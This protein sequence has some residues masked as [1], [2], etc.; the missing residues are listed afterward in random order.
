MLNNKIL[1]LIA[2][3][4]I[5][6]ISAF[7]YL[8]KGYPGSTTSGYMVLMDHP[9][10]TSEFTTF[11]PE[12]YSST[13]YLPAGTCDGFVT[14]CS[15]Y[16][17]SG[18]DAKYDVTKDGRIDTVDLKILSTA[19]G[20]SGSECDQTIS[21]TDCYF[22]Y[23]NRRFKDPNDDCYMDQTDADIV[24]NNYGKTISPCDTSNECRSDINKDGKV[25][26]YDTVILAKKFNSYADEVISYSIKKRDLDFN[27]DGSVGLSDLTALAKVYGSVANEQKCETNTLTHLSGNTWQASASGRGIYHIGISYICTL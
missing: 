20:C 2:V 18:V 6:L 4:G 22:V 27:G 8:A 9:T 24:K 7:T 14:S 12:S 23:K 21:L 1:V 13:V 10:T 17:P 16:F 25:D 5:L 3:V 15:F 19:Y 26:L 11:T